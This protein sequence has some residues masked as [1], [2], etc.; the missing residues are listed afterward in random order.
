M[1][2]SSII[3]NR[4]AGRLFLVGCMGLLG[5]FCVH[6][7]GC[8]SNSSSEDEQKKLITYTKINRSSDEPTGKFVEL[9]ATETGLDFSTELLPDHELAR[10]Y[11]G[12]FAT[13]GIAVADID[14]DELPDIFVTGGPRQNRLFRQTGRLKFEDISSQAGFPST[15]SAWS[16]SASFCG[17]R[18]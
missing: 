6:F 7:A 4:I 13:G 9:S 18:E 1:C 8:G 17:Y 3:R 15:S 16:I 14:G 2:G 5:I 10:L 11:H 12:G